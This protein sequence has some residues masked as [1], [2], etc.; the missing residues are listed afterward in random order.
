MLRLLG[1]GI[2]NA[3]RLAVF[4]AGIAKG[5]S[6]Q[7]AAFAA[8]N[9]TVD[10]AKSGYAMRLFNMWLPFTNAR[11]QAAI[12]LGSAG[13]SS[14]KDSKK[15]ARFAG[16]VS[17]IIGA[18]TLA[19]YL[20]N[21][22]AYPELYTKVNDFIKENYWF[23]ILGS[24]IDE[25]TGQEVPVL[26]TIP[27]GDA[28]KLFGNPI[29]NFAMYVDGRDPGE[30]DKMALDLFSDISPIP[31]ARKG[32]LNFKLLLSGSLPVPIKLAVESVANVNLFT[33]KPIDP[34]FIS[35]V[36]T[37][38]ISPGLRFTKQTSNLSKFIGKKLNISPNKIDN[39]IGGQFAGAGRIA[40]N[41]GGP[42]FLKSLTGTFLKKGRI[43]VKEDFMDI[44]KKTA[45]EFADSDLI[46][47]RKAEE[48]LNDLKT[49]KTNQKR[50]EIL[51]KL[52]KAGPE[53]RS[54]FI[55]TI[56]DQ[57]TPHIPLARMASSLGVKN[58]ARAEFIFRSLNL[59][60]TPKEKGE[61]LNSL[62]DGGALSIDVL[63][64]LQEKI[65]KNA[66]R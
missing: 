14:L 53:A 54:K 29:E 65:D 19:T 34:E 10:F 39:A 21:T 35:G 9:S 58:G 57:N 16:T 47:A 46:A 20:Y 63:N 24:E 2:E 1:E 41:I 15:A 44:Y 38:R 5:M 23:M 27:K 62:K 11:L 50:E 25:N 60:K 56:Q 51:E 55:K 22:R 17:A 48:T 40:S 6:P 3:P 49:A 33:G 12:N 52:I 7:Q 43:V 8:R 30:W 36:Q 18:P 31:F 59:F 28:G 61:F 32:D 37:E 4:Q 45:N 42:N 66:K 13:I 26:A 64:Q